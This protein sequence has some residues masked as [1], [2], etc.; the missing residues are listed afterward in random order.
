MHSMPVPFTLETIVDG[1][2]NI[3]NH[4]NTPQH[5]TQNTSIITNKTPTIDNTK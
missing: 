1:E 5:K 2:L 4:S 3:H